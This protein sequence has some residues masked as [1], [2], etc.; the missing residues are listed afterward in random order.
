MLL[1]TMEAFI[2]FV[3]ENTIQ[4]IYVYTLG[5]NDRIQDR[6]ECSV[7]INGITNDAASLLKRQ[8][9]GTHME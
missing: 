4:R 7:C 6:I 9:T 1:L 3:L 2:L 5:G 8:C